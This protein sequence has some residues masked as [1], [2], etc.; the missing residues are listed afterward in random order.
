MKVRPK[1]YQGGLAFILLLNGVKEI[2]FL[3]ICFNNV[4]STTC[5][6]LQ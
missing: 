4:N 3:T 6:E 2:K 1:R 5:Y